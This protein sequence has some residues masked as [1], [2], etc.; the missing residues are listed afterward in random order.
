MLTEYELEMERQSKR[1][2]FIN[3]IS[4]YSVQLC[5]MLKVFNCERLCCHSGVPTKGFICNKTSQFDKGFSASAATFSCYLW[6]CGT[7]VS[8]CLKP[9]FHIL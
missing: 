1:N 5:Y 3:I 9:L 2:S 8:E 6:I 4:V 7:E